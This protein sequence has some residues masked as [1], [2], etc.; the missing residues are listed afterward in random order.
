ML[1]CL[2]VLACCSRGGGDTDTTGGERVISLMPSGTE[3]VA[4]LGAE[5]LLV[6]VDRYSSYPPLTASLPKVGDYLSPDVEAI[7]RLHPTFVI[8]DDVH[9]QVAAALHD[10]GIETIGCSIHTLPDVKAGLRAVGARLGKARQA[11]AVVAEMDAA[12]DAAAAH[13]PAR[14]PRVLAVIDREAGGIG[15]L[16]AAGPGSYV[17]ELLAVVGGDNVLAPTGQRYPQIALEEVLRARPEVIVDLSQAAQSRMDD[18]KA[19]EVPAV[20]DHRVVALTDPTLQ[21]PSPR[22]AHAL[23]AL[24]RAI[25]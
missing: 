1:P 20:A 3:I 17:D 23:D 24:A 22:V 10:H 18:W 2:I 12:L 9:G 11:E 6:G 7:V 13:R 5:S 14:H 19:V 4:A 8:V 25:R 21:G 15:R 16:V